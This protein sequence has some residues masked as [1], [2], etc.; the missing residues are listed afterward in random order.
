M[1]DYA[2]TQMRDA[3]IA[4]LF[5]QAKHDR[6]IIFISNE[7]GAPSLDI[8]REELPEQFINAGISEQNIISVA[9]GIALEGKKVFVYS[10]ASF[11]TLRCFEQIK[12]DMCVHNAPVT[13]LAVGTGFA[14][15]EDGPTHH[16]TEDIG[17]MRTLA[18]LEIWSPSDAKQSSELVNICLNKQFPRYIRFDKGKFPV[19]SE[20]FSYTKDNYGIFG[21]ADS[22]VLLITTGFMTHRAVDVAQK[23][24]NYGICVTVVDLCR[25]K[26]LSPDLAEVTGKAKYIFTIEEH[27]INAGLGSMIAEFV[28]DNNCTARLKRFAIKDDLLY[29]YGV[30]NKIHKKLGLDLESLVSSIINYLEQG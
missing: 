24:K 23:L 17:V 8:F 16:A 7:F 1:P 26:P 11:I 2:N 4:E 22:E 10:I 18:N 15:S 19:L 13:I 21:N 29:C 25:L 9:S 14:Y 28:L 12:L 20:T 30:R 27:T 3:F 6:D 5:E